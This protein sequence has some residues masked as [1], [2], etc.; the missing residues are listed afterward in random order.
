MARRWTKSEIKTLKENKKK[1]MKEIVKK[2][3][4]SEKAIRSKAQRDGVSLKPKDKK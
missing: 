4:R 2:I 1:P 3:D